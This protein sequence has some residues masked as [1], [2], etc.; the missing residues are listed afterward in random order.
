MNSP[1]DPRNV[2]R[3]NHAHPINSKILPNG[4]KSVVYD[5]N[6]TTKEGFIRKGFCVEI[7]NPDSNTD[8]FLSHVYP[9]LESAMSVFNS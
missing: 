2:A 8:N 9:R 7:I 3:Y 6:V 5:V 4:M 1:I